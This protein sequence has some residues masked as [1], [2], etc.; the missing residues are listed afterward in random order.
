MASSL[1]PS[2]L[3]LIFAPVEDGPQLRATL[4]ACSTVSHLWRDVAL[5]YLFSSLK[6]RRHESFADVI[7]FLSTRPYIAAC[8]K[9]LWLHR[10][11]PPGSP[12]KPEVD[13]DTV[14]ALL[15]RLP[16]LVNLT[17]HTVKFV[18]HCIQGDP[19]PSAPQASPHS[20]A[21]GLVPHAAQSDQKKGNGAYRLQLIYLYACTAPEGPTP[22]FR[23]LS[24]C[25][26]D[27]LRATLN[28][29]PGTD[30]AQVD[31]AAL[32]RP[33][34]VRWLRVAVQK[35]PT[36]VAKRPPPLLEA[37][38]RALEPGCV[39]ELDV[40]LHTWDDVRTVRALLRNAGHNLASLRLN[41]SWD[42]ESGE[43]ESGTETLLALAGRNADVPRAD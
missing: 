43:G 38:H 11:G 21:T 29:L 23:I 6:V 36:R 5:P 25:E 2:L 30:A 10:S 39:R 40:T 15:A 4:F 9:R 14:H 19:V 28:Q 26:M 42:S 37:L 7:A 31:L 24:L 18:D 27:T 41:V 3:H 16:A 20:S 35:R 13:H 34:R 32:H 12:S 22:L 17:F 8:I 1:P 33:L